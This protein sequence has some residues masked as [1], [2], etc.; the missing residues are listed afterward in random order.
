M[1]PMDEPCLYEIRVE[2]LLSDHWSDWF[3]GL[4]LCSEGGTTTL[5]GLLP[6]QAALHGVL[7]KIHDLNLVLVEVRR[8]PQKSKE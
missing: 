1:T 3:E 4:E 2:G 7:R 8:L 6:D 5:S